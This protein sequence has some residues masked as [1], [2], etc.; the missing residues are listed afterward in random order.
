MRQTRLSA[1]AGSWNSSRN[2]T[3]FGQFLEE[4]QSLL[5]FGRIYYSNGESG[6]DQYII[7]HLHVGGEHDAYTLL[8]TTDL[9]P[10]ILAFDGDYPCGYREAHSGLHCNPWVRDGTN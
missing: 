1:S 7:A 9:N 4:S 6:V 5:S 2:F 3:D 10:G 8:Y